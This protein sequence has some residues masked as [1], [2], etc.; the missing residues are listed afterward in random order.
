MVRVL[1]RYAF[2]IN[3]GSGWC[4]AKNSEP[5]EDNL[6][7]VMIPYGCIKDARVGRTNLQHPGCM[8]KGDALSISETYIEGM[9]WGCLVDSSPYD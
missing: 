5:D 4:F 6:N 2:S 1:S 7:Y 3:N 9:H 8:T